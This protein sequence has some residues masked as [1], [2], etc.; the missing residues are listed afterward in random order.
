MRGDGDRIRPAWHGARPDVGRR[1]AASGCC[2]AVV[3]AATG[4]FAATTTAQTG[5]VKNPAIRMLIVRTEAEARDAIAA[6]GAGL[7][8]GQVVRERSVG[9]E[10]ERGGYL[11][12][13]DPASLS[14]AAR[15]AVTATRPGR[16]TPVFPTEGGFGVIQVLTDRE[17]REE[18]ERLS[19]EPEALAILKQGT[20]LGTQGDLEGAV[21]LLRRAVELNPALADAHFNLAVALARLGR[22][23]KAI[24]AMQE[25]LRLQPKDFDA[26]AR[27]GTWLSGQGRHGEAIAHLERAVAL[28]VNSRD[29]W[30]KLA[31][32]YDAA[33]RPQAAVGAYRRVLGL[34][35]RDDAALLEALLRVAMAAP[36]GPAAVD[37]ARRLR[38][39]RPGH[40]GFLTMLNGEAE[41]AVR[42]YRM[43]VG[44]APKSARA[45][46]GLAAALAALQQTESA[47]EQLLQSIQLDPANP[48]HYQKLSALYERMGR[49]DM[50]IVALRDGAT[51]ATTSPRGIQAEIAD[52][53]AALYDRADMRQDAARERARAQSLRSP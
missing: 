36:D 13:V 2:L 16:L 12:R 29:A 23:D 45:R 22:M 24:V 15:A 25:V 33:G 47:A 51:A 9:P 37:A 10:R 3:L 20:D 21:T 46:A 31:Q 44:L 11:G 38:A 42:E 52:R 35:G 41:A 43:A 19:R 6:H 30:L 34:A 32:G 7:A 5:P 28:E 40:E 26:H 48:V 50:A 39:L 49:L 1:A 8:F 53:L 18:E 17:A 14:P 27:L 4:V